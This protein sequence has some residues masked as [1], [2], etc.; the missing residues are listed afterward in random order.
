M[1]NFSN[2]NVSVNDLLGVIPEGLISHLS[3]ST[4]V[5]HYAKVLHGKKMFYLLL[6]GIL[7]NDRLSQ[8]TLEDTF[9]DP[10]FKALFGLNMDEKVRHSSI[11][12]RL[13]TI[14]PYYFRQIYDCVYNQFATCYS[15]AEI[16]KYNLI[17]VDSSMV[18][19]TSGRMACGL[20]NKRGKLA[21]KYTT[22]FDGFLP[23]EMS[24]FTEQSYCNENNALPEVV[25]KHVKQQTDHRNI[26]LLDRGLQSAPSMS[27][28]SDEAVRFVVRAKE[29]RKHTKVDSIPFADTDL[30]SLELVSQDKIHLHNSRSADY[31][32]VFRL[33]VARSKSDNQ[34]EYWFI[35]ND[36]A[37]TA[38]EITDAYRKRWDIE[39]F[40]RFIKQELNA[41]HL[42]SLNK[43]G[44]EVVLYMT[45]IVGMLV[46][47][48][49]RANDIGYKTAKRRFAMEIRDL[50]IALIVIE[51]GGDPNIFFK[52]KKE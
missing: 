24:L 22:A 23:C 1:A 46:L 47:I 28:F 34:G 33:I 30:G 32:E 18:S 11:S 44:I 13:A 36:F 21:V 40:F 15:G 14:Q 5:D 3:N 48:Y 20:D 52:T 38:K 43:N 12:D 29:G 39:V 8:R 51:C 19:D 10:I 35:T 26:Y 2:H 16:E 37:L 6:Y 17:R 49:K 9:N 7:E 31:P 4:T 45:M 27:A 25:L 41:S 50:A 42:I